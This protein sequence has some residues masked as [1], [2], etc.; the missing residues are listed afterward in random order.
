MWTGKAEELQ[1]VWEGQAILLPFLKLLPP[2]LCR[3]LVSGLGLLSWESPCAT[4]WTTGCLISQGRREE[5]YLVQAEDHLRLPQP[6]SI[7]G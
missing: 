1:D 2:V 3:G 7:P 5:D 6:Y 4:Q